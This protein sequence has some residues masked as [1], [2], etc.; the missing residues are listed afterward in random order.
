MSIQRVHSS[1]DDGQHD[2][3]GSA[4]FP[5]GDPVASRRRFAFAANIVRQVIEAT[6][7]GFATY[8]A[9]YHGLPL[10]RLL[11]TGPAQ[12]D[13]CAQPKLQSQQHKRKGNARGRRGFAHAQPVGSCAPGGSFLPMARVI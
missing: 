8:G 7:T 10:A 1:S 5:T 11:E 12:T 9:A 4:V 3:A 2:A 13:D 6:L